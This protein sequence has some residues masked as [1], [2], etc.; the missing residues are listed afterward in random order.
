MFHWRQRSIEEVEWEK[1]VDDDD[2]GVVV[3]LVESADRDDDDAEKRGSPWRFAFRSCRCPLRVGR[4]GTETPSRS[5]RSLS[6]TYQSTISETVMS[7]LP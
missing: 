4:G 1:V 2:D 5:A 7:P 3:V 6:R